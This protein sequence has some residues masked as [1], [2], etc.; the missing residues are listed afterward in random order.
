MLENRGIFYSGGFLYN[1]Q[2]QAVLLHLRDNQTPN[3]PN[4]WAFFGGQNEGAESPEN[5]FIREL[6]EELGIIIE[7]GTPQYLCD[8]LNINRGTWR[9]IFYIESN[10]SKADMKLTEGADF[11]WIPLSKVFSY[12][13]TDKTKRDLKRFIIKLSLSKDVC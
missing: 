6:G 2:A 9:Y 8:Y 13:L 12:D 1:P 7:K 5:C 3:N 11:D 10:K 4:K